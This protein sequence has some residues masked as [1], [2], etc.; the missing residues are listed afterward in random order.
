[1]L[2][3]WR[4]LASS[5]ATFLIMGSALLAHASGIPQRTAIT[6]E[7]IASALLMNGI[8]V[9]HDQVERLSD[10]TAFGSGAPRLQVVSVHPQDAN[11]ANVRLKCSIASVCLPF[12][13]LLHWQDPDEATSTLPKW[14]KRDQSRARGERLT[15]D[16]MLVRSGK[17]A[18]LVLA[19][20]NTRITIP[21][22]CLQNGARRQSVRV[23]NKDS[24]RVYL[25]KV[26]AA[27]LVTSASLN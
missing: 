27:G 2:R 12:Y 15:P 10:I 16:E 18:T 13:V 11:T 5:S 26:I 14:Q 6:R 17:T 21:V 9:T 4:S 19:S 24:K 25:A 8:N 3:N 23:M 20:S 7:Q 1:M 22:L